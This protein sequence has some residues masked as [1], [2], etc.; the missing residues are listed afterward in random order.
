MDF[1][2][3]PLSG[4]V[5]AF[6][7]HFSSG[8]I[9]LQGTDVTGCTPV[10]LLS[11]MLPKCISRVPKREAT[12]LIALKVLLEAAGVQGSAALV[13]WNGERKADMHDYAFLLYIGFGP[14][15]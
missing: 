9:D 8:S 3:N 7:A 5:P 14:C 12:A 11:D 15:M 4:T 2:Y 13:A 10:G 1:A 6:W